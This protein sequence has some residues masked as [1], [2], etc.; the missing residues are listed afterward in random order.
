MEKKVLEDSRQLNARETQRTPDW[1][2]TVWCTSTN[3]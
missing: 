2:A 1:W 3:F